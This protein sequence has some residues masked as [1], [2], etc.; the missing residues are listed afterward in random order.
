MTDKIEM[1]TV[2]SRGQICIP[3]DIRAEMGIKEGSKVLFA[4]T[5]DSLIMKR[6]SMETFREITMPLKEAIKKSVL[7]E[8]DIPEIIHRFRA[9]KKAKNKN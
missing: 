6:V 3:N 5:G 9:G 4:L 2:S 8:S 1:A 7:K